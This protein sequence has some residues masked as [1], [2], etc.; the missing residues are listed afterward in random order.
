MKQYRMLGIFIYI[1]L[2]IASLWGGNR[3][4]K[5]TRQ[6][7]LSSAADRQ[8]ISHKSLLYARHFDQQWKPVDQTDEQRQPASE[9]IPAHQRSIL[10]IGID[11]FLTAEPKLESLWMIF[12]L[13]DLPQFMLVP[14]YPNRMPGD[15][16]LP[17][18]DENLASSFR[19]MN[20]ASPHPNFLQALHDKD[21]WWNGYLILDKSALLQIQ[22][23]SNK[24]ANDPEQSNPQ[25][26]IHHTGEDPLQALFDQTR[27]AQQLC[28][29]SNQVLTT[30]ASEILAFLDQISTHMSTD[31]NLH[32]LLLEL[33]QALQTSG[34]VSCEFPTL[35]ALAWQR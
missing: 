15:S 6:I 10:L 9:P 2:G 26:G 3:L 21:I 28:R 25:L 13:R 33:Q 5:L 12:Y 34:G 1:F 14:I 29:S 22:E 8:V 11:D 7:I 35:V 17:L 20:N 32:M 27:L 16:P 24:F 19:L 23:F 30:D 31:L 18:I 4:G